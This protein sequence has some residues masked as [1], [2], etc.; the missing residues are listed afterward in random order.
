[1]L[2]RFAQVIC[3]TTHDII[4]HHVIIT[5]ESAVIIGSSDPLR[6]HTV[7]AP[8]IVAMK[9][10]RETYTEPEE[11]SKMKGVKPGVTLPVFLAGEV[12]GSIAIAGDHREV[13]R[14]GLLVQKQAE[15]FLREQLIQESAGA[16]ERALRELVSDIASFAPEQDD[17]AVLATR[18]KEL[19]Y[20]MDVHRVCLVME[21]GP[22]DPETAEKMED[23]IKKVSISTGAQEIIRSVFPEPSCFCSGMGH[24]RFVVFAAVGKPDV[25]TCSPPIEEKCGKCRSL[26]GDMGLNLTIGAGSCARDPE[27]LHYSYCEAWK[28]LAIGLKKGEPG[29]NHRIGDYLLED[30]LSTVNIR[31]GRRFSRKHLSG[32]RKM[33]D[34][35]DMVKTFRAWCESPCNPG[36][37]AERLN[38]HRNTL[39][40]RLEK[41]HRITGAD[42][43]NFR[44]A[45]GL[46]IA[47][48][49]EMLHE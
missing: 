43:K 42:L 39:N 2:K 27:G 29:K 25:D 10:K 14:Y 20:D 15:L 48:T 40:Y 5:D 31:K 24:T 6:L 34:G 11:A 19:G 1:M 17:S 26:L 44:E 41:I 30:L 28:A 9:Q 45:F 21:L 36:K 12:V 23:P 46:F 22:D 16:R 4:G 32:L 7:H 38:I 13:A 33:P 18:V 3:E 47:V 49:L 8:S 35:D 37:V